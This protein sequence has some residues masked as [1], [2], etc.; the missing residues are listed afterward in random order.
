MPIR[1][2]VIILEDI[3]PD[4]FESIVGVDADFLVPPR[5]GEWVS[6]FGIVE[7][8]AHY[9]FRPDDPVYGRPSI[10]LYVTRKDAEDAYRT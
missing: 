5:L 4:S 6:G 8:V 2:R 7:R 10:V 3:S 9:P 1:C